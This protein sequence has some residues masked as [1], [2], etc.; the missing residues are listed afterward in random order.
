MGRGEKSSLERHISINVIKV[1]WSPPTLGL[2]MQGSV[3]RLTG[4][5]E[6]SA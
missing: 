2:S 3:G 4:R 6:K 5:K 1:I